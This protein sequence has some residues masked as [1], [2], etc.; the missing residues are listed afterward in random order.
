M[1]ICFIRSTNRQDQTIV[2]RQDGVRLSV[3]V[4][5]PLEPIPHDL[6]HY[7]VEKE[8]DLHD[9]LWAS[10][11]AGAV[12][13]GMKVIS[14]RRPPHAKERSHAIQVANHRGILLAELAVD[15]VLRAIKGEPLG[16]EPYIID[17]PA[18]SL[19]TRKDHVALAQRVRPEME[20]MIARWQAIPMGETLIVSWPDTR[21]LRVEVPKRRS[22]HGREGFHQSTTRLM[23]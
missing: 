19:R 13:E 17:P 9:G 23:R 2:T 8:L 10:I 6:A 16:D 12:L 1:D 20:A 11:A 14:G 15:T 18:L 5:G 21:V 7:V 22:H 4:F 3:P